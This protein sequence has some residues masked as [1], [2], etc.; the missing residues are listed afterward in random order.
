VENREEKDGMQTPGAR[1]G[2]RLRRVLNYGSVVRQMPF[3]LFLAVLAV[4]YIYNG[5]AADRLNRDIA[6]TSRELKE[7]EYEYKTVKGDV[8]FR[9]KQSELV[10]AVEPLGL[11]EMSTAP[12]VVVDSV[13][14]D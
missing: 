1:A 8:L 3:F 10:K 12:M 9:S 5:H 14:G 7:L 2:F 13:S 11:K 6:R 4:V